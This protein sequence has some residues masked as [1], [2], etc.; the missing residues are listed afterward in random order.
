MKE[1]MVEEVEMD[2]KE[3]QEKKD[4]MMKFYTESM[5]YLEAQL[6]YEKMLLKIDKARF[7]RT[8]IQV[9]YAMM[10]NPG[11]DQD[12]E[13]MPSHEEM[14]EMARRNMEEEQSD[15]PQKQPRKLKKK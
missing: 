14:A 6:K 13:N 3:L 9:Q 15:A 10:M 1:E 8:S 12:L 11:P 5:P 2:E 4:E 7:Q